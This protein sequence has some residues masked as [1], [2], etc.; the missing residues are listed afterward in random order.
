MNQSNNE[1]SNFLAE[2]AGEATEKLAAKRSEQQDQQAIT[3]SV[4]AALERTYK[5]FHL[6]TK[7]L[8]ALEPEVPRI[9]ALDGKTQ[10]SGIK[11]RSGMA[12]YRKQSIA[13]NALMNHV[14]FQVRLTLPAPVTVTRRWEQ[15]E[16]TRK[17]LDAYGLKTEEDMHELWRNRAQKV[18]FQITIEPEFIV[19]MRFLG[20]YTDG[21]VELESNN[22]DGFGVLKGKLSPDSLQTNILDGVGRFLMGRSNA[23]PQELALARDNSRNR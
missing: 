16:E 17:D 22:L 21:R 1:M 20:N 11:W 15:F 3:Q 14:Y 10:F 13:D 19:W 8:N 7:H 12:E 9:Y 5:F 4:N 6:L 2:L 23:L 18:T